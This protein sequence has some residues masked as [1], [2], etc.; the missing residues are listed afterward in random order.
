[1][2]EI[3]EIGDPNKDNQVGRC[4]IIQPWNFI[5]S[6]FP[7]LSVACYTLRGLVLWLMVVTGPK[8][9]KGTRALIQYDL[10]YFIRLSGHVSAYADQGI[11]VIVPPCCN[12]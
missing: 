12:L 11:V 1:M 7:S 4:V 9:L 2:A 10:I 6:S 3:A 8:D 5:H